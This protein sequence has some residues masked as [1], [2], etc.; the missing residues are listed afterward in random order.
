[1]FLEWGLKTSDV[2]TIIMS[3]V[4]PILNERLISSMEFVFFKPVRLIDPQLLQKLDLIVPSPYEI[5][6][7]LVA[8]AYCAIK[9][10]SPKAII[11]DF[12]TALSFTVV[13]EK[14][15]IKG[16]TIAPG[17][18]TAV[19]SL[20]HATAQLP[21]VSLNVPKS[22]IGTNTEEAIQAGVCIGYYGLISEILKRMHS[23]LGEGYKTIATGGLVNCNQEIVSL[24]DIIDRDLT[25][26]GIYLINKHLNQ[27]Q[28]Q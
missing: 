25:L 28:T 26:N 10:H 24:F 19:N 15:G 14:E 22:S 21:E 6:S 23:E 2:K 3:S 12:G 9:S 20:F 11:V 5:G 17:L 4:V 16:V 27:K 7:D 1:L 8:N 18:T 13:D